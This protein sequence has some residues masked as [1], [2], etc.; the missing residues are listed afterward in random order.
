MRRKSLKLGFR[1]IFS[2]TVVFSVTQITMSLVDLLQGQSNLVQLTYVEPENNFELQRHPLYTICPIFEQSANLSLPGQTLR[3]VMINNT[4]FYPTVLLLKLLNSP[5]LEAKRYTTWTKMID[6][7]DGLRQIILV[8]CQTFDISNDIAIGG[9][10]SK[11][12]PII[13]NIIIYLFC[14]PLS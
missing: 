3:T 9:M 6:T 2:I 1:A 13:T 10:E 5:A 4:V 8:Q 14:T 12:R 7:V 11:V